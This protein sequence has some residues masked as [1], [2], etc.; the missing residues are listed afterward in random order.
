MAPM[1]DHVAIPVPS[2][3]SPE[4]L[5]RL[6]ELVAEG[7]RAPKALAELLGCNIR[8]LQS[9]LHAGEWLGFIE[10]GT[11]S[12]LGD[13]PTAPSISVT[14]PMVRLTRLGLDYAFGDRRRERIWADAVWSQ[15]FIRTLMAGRP[16][17]LPPAS[18]VVKHVLQEQ[19]DLASAT[20][21]RRASAVRGLLEP[22]LNVERRRVRTW[23]GTQLLLGFSR[24]REPITQDRV[25]VTG[26]D[27]DQP[28]DPALYRVVLQALL[29]EGEVDV[30]HLRGILDRCG[31][32]AVAV[33]G[34]AEMALRRGDAVRVADGLLDKLVATPEA[35]ARRDLSDTVAS[36]AL[37]DPEY[38]EYLSVMVRTERGDPAAAIRY[39][40][41]R[42]RFAHWDRRLFGPLVK[43]REM[44]RA[45]DR[46]LLGRPLDAFPVAR[47]VAG[48][49]PAIEQA[50]FLHLLGA[51]DLRLALPPS[52]DA[53]VGGVQAVNRSLA[54][55]QRGPTRV[56]LPAATDIRV[57]FHGGVFHPGERPPRAVADNITLRLLAVT[58]VPWLT[59]LA[60]FLLLHRR[61]RGRLTV[62]I[63]GDQVHVVY[64]RRDRGP[65]L[66]VVDRLMRGRG[67]VVS[68]RFRGGLEATTL[69]DV[70]VAL[71]IAIEVEGRLFLDENF[72]V[73]MRGEPEDGE[74]YERLY[75]FCNALEGELATV[76][77]DEA[78]TEE[79][80][81]ASIAE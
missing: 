7:I 10:P 51:S 31:A 63:R 64:R 18:L 41:L 19:P 8:T 16:P 61:S 45:M 17:E 34:Y 73:R 58:R 5:A 50:P 25:I 24:P 28:D 60:A 27:G 47:P 49:H 65:L 35:V 26:V 66:E 39:G 11:L 78:G 22:A 77:D 80:D 2:A 59:Y 70:A 71:G 14:G 9:Y 48:G 62:R 81:D 79:A 13:D 72:F 12:R 4:L 52:L 56:C 40:R 29:D 43:P 46:L 23:Q 1:P 36:V 38:R 32:E 15:P 37:S 75:A 6:L 30:T 54:A 33:G 74:V 44:A 55:R 21:L 42:A 3:S 57:A 68:R 53:L 20:A 69:R 67:W 76:T